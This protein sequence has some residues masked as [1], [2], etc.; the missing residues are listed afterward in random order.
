MLES[1]VNVFREF[2]ALLETAKLYGTEHPKF[3]D[4]LNRAYLSLQAVLRQRE[5]LIFGIIADELAFENEVL[6]DL[7][8]QIAPAI[9][10]LKDRQIER[11]VFYHGLTSEELK[12]LVVYLAAAKKDITV[13]PQEYLNSQGI[14]N[15]ALGK[16]KEASGRGGAPGG[17]QAEI[18]RAYQNSLEKVSLSLSG[19]L[20]EE[21]IDNLTLRL[22]INSIMQ[23]MASYHQELLKLTTL[24][25]YDAVSYVH[26]LN[27]AILAMYFSSKLGFS[28]DDVLDI[29]LAALFHDIGKMYISRKILTKPESLSDEEFNKI[30]SHTVMGAELLMRYVPMLGILPPVV[31]FEHHLKYDLSGYPKMPFKQ[32]PHM[33]SL[34]VSICD[35]Y[36][37][38]SQ[39]R[40]YKL[41][42]SP[43]MI[44]NVMTSEKGTTFEPELLD[45]FFRIMG[46]WP[47]GSLVSLTDGRIAV[48]HDENEDDVASPIVEVIFPEDKKEMIDLAQTKDTLK[49]NRYLNPWKEG[50]DFLHLIRGS[51]LPPDKGEANKEI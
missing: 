8:K 42:Y 32:K 12:K 27:V 14:K 33:V 31:A 45:K 41:D 50:K 39:R 9:K 13:T 44:Y 5:E 11:I 7:T 4:T 10:Y 15:I 1:I 28:K 25:R 21:A 47:I 37:A 23:N 38:L 43:E 26:I 24:K 30:K 19:M 6:F 20:N 29:G 34:L 16:I 17:G 46:I 2:L 18:A 36:D 49:I 35:V 48:V 51:A 22:A 3:A 40:G